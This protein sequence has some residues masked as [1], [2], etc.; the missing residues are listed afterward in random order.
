M[1]TLIF[2]SALVLSFSSFAQDDMNNTG[3][4]DFNQLIENI[5]TKD[6]TN[7]EVQE[8]PEEL[9]APET[10]EAPESPEATTDLKVAKKDTVQIRVGKHNV[11]VITDGENTQI[12][13]EKIKDFKSRWEN[14]DWDDEKIK[15]I[16]HKNHNKKFDGHW[17]SFDF[18]GNMLY[19]TNYDNYAAGTP[20]FL[21][22]RPEKSF[23][24]NINFAEYS[25]GFG[26]YIGIVTG[27]GFNFND[28]KFKNQ[29][30]I[31]AIDGVLQP[32]ALPN[33]DFRLSKLSTGFLTAPLMLEIQ[34]PGNGGE[35]RL[36]IAG[37]LI[38]GLKM[39][40]HTKTRI[41]DQ[42]LKN[43]GDHFVSPLRW[44][45]TARI[46]FED[47]GVFATYY[48]TELFESGKG[49]VTNPLT[50]GLTFSF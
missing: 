10:P 11:E 5:E 2:L 20:H 40:E 23:E 28:Y 21:D 16:K 46:G 3:S 7:V 4:S 42:K 1:K 25:F 43:K 13:V 45:Y 18:G 32:V 34:I 30:T 9:K 17:D 26:Q 39:G 24:C 14:N 19:K 50:I 31:E 8:Q 49:P 27:L 15:P 35:D 41:G 6:T 47:M 44:G 33:E 22:I 12:E 36:F 29:Y 48:V 37:G 38:G